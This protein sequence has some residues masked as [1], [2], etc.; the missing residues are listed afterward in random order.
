M[1]V[2]EKCEHGSDKGSCVQCWVSWVTRQQDK[3]ESQTEKPAVLSPNLNWW[4][5]A[6]LDFL[7]KQ[8]ARHGGVKRG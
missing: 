4:F 5:S 1:S 3:V 6:N 8:A 7:R 2:V